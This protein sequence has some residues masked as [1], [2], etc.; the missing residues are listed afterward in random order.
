MFAMA[1]AFTPH[2]PADADSSHALRFNTNQFVGYVDLPFDAYGQLDST[3]WNIWRANDVA[4]IFALGGYGVFDSTALYFDCGN[5]DDLG[6]NYHAAIFD[7]MT[8]QAGV[9]HTFEVYPGYDDLF[10]ADHTMLIAQ[11]L[12]K[13]AKFYSDYFYR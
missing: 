8:T 12:K 2:D 3:I 4:T 10:K 5:Q 9:S 13:V 1:V 6:L 7:A 11:R